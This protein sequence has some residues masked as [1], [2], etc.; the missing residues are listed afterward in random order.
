MRT[1]RERATTVNAPIDKFL[2]DAERRAQ[3]RGGEAAV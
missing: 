3:A 2:A 1:T